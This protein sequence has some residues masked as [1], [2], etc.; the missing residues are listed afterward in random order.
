VDRLIV[1]TS[2]SSQDRE[3]RTGRE[4]NILPDCHINARHGICHAIDYRAQ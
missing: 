1:I 4:G 3:R 2:S